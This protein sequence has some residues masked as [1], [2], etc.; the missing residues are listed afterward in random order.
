MKITIQDEQAAV[1]AVHTELLIGGK[2][3]PATT[4]ARLD[5]V[6]PSTGTVLCAVAD[7]SPE[8]GMA[9]LE[10]SV[11]A[12]AAFA[13][14][15]PRA[16]AAI[17]HRAHQLLLEREDQFALLVTLE[18]GKPLAEARG[19]VVFAAEHLRH[20]AE[21]AVRIDGSYRHNPVGGGRLVGTKQPVGPAVLI[22]PWN[23]PLAMVARKIAPAVAS[24]CTSV[25]KPAME[26]PLTMLALA[27]LFQEAGLPDGA[28]NVVP[29]TMPGPLVEPLLRSGKARKLSFTGSTAVGVVLLEQAAGKVLRTSMELGGNAPFVVFAD[30]DLDNALEGLMQTKMRS[31]GETCTAA[32]RVYV[33][34]SIM[35]TFAAR[36][37][38]RMKD[39]VQGRG[40]EEGVTLGPL[41]S[42]RQ[43]K[44]VDALVKNAVAAGA[45]LLTG[46]IVPNGPGYFYPPTVLADV[47]APARL[48]REEIFGPVAPLIPFDTEDEVISA[49]NDTE[50]GL[51]AYVFTEDYR[52]G[53]RVC[54][55]METGMVALNQ[56]SV[57]GAAAPFGGIKM[58]GL[59]REG[60]PEG[61]TEYL[62]TKL[63]AVKF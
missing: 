61:I 19:E 31:A 42:E 25:V 16:R 60:G 1:A 32:N 2:W 23:F 40:V 55:A 28:L 46:G 39:F 44:R 41:I 35:D 18:V 15:A 54:E 47:P 43:R 33:H 56:G 52:R 57:S 8:D 7:A 48:T 10:A 27:E 3:M 51:V 13:A 17:L 6:D 59:G 50:Y 4:G 14:L 24:G 20:S 12:Q 26:T 62:E 49:A 9:A 37:V 38:E 30:T 5:V 22:A 45:N 58:S 36:L 53:L 21:E 11:A 29:T 34:R 63:I